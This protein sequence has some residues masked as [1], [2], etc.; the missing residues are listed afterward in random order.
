MDDEKD[1]I[2]LSFNTKGKSF[3]QMSQNS[4][5]SFTMSIKRLDLEEK[6][7]NFMVQIIINDDKSPKFDMKMINVIV[8]YKDN[9]VPEDTSDSESSSNDE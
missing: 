7:Q 2:K 8:E 9:Y 3:I 4:D 1:K 6:S 5:N